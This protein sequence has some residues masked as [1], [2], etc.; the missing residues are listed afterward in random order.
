MNITE[1]LFYIGVNDH[2]IDLFE[3]Q[4]KVP[5]G[6]SYNSYLLM[7][8]KIAIF[9]TVDANFANEWLTNI[10]SILNQRQPD[11]LIIQ[12]MEPDHSG[13]I[14]S[15]LK[16][17]PNITIVGNKKTF[18][19]LEQFF[20]YHF[21]N[22]LMVNENDP[23]LLGKHTLKFI[24]A[25]MVHWPEV[26]FTY[27]TSEHLL[28]SADGFGKFGALDVEEAW[29]DEARRYYFGIVGKYGAQVQNILKKASALDIKI[30]CPLHGPIL[31]ENLN[32]YLQYYNLWSSYE[33]E[34]N[35][36]V[37]AY[38]SVYGNTKKAVDT[39]VK[40]LKE[41]NV[42]EITLIDLA[43]SDMADAI[44]KA[45]KYNKLILAGVTYNGELFPYMKTFVSAL[46][47]RNYQKRKIGI[48]E[49]GSWAP[50]VAKNIKNSFAS[51]QNIE[52]TPTVV[53]ILSAMNDQNLLELNELA[54]EII[55]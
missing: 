8:E 2:Q 42:S 36:I 21:T 12:H 15:L 14:M 11:Y 34:T 47:E 5:N 13:S 49:N 19:M 46:L 31:K 10:K 53:R 3:G 6:I 4:Y 22:L 17:Y 54:K 24:L 37:I 18:T 44:A 7:D 40:N 20:K 23:L 30:I 25:P 38:T 32:T 41:K 16:V 1:N 45:F 51:A 27:E 48:I 33:P 9:D 35:G 28:F 29:L 52:F 39:F 50:M 55:E 26:M 43:R